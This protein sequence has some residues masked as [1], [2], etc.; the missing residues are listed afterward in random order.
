VISRR[1]QEGGLHG[2]RGFPVTSFELHPLGHDE[3]LALAHQLCEHAPIPATE[4]SEL[5]ER[6]GGNPLFLL[7]LVRARMEAG[8]QATLPS[9]LEGIIASRLDR[10]AAGDRRILRHVAVLG[11]RFPPDLAST[12]L[13]DLVPEILDQRAWH[14]LGEFLVDEQ[15]DVRFSHSLLR[16]VAYEGLPYSRR[17]V[18]HHR[19][20]SHLEQQPGSPDALRLSLMALHFDVANTTSKA[21]RYSRLAGDRA[22]QNGANPEAASFFERALD[23]A[24]RSDDVA[25]DELIEVAEALG[26]VAELAARYDKA[27]SGYRMARRIAKGDVDTL[28]RLSRKEGLLRERTARYPAALAWYRK[29]RT[30]AD[31]LPEPDASSQRAELFVA[32]AGV[33]MHQGRLRSCITW[34]ER[35]LDNAVIAGNRRA[36]A[37]AY[38]LLDVA[39]TDLGSPDAERYR[40]RS[41]PIFEEIGDLAGVARTLGNLSVDARYEGRWD[42]ALELAERSSEAQ[43]R[44]GDVTGL[45]MSRYNAAEVL[46]DQGKLEL[47]E[48]MLISARRTWRAGAFTLGVAVA[49]GALGRLAV[50]SR[51]D[52]RALELIDQAVAA[53]TG[54]GADAWVAEISAHRVEADLFAGRW[55]A[56]LGATDDSEGSTGE[57]QDAALTSKLLRFRGVAFAAIGDHEAAAATLSK[58][59]AVASDSGAAYELALA[60]LERSRLPGRDD[61]DADRLAAA[62]TL[63]S[64]GVVAPHVLIP[65]Y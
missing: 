48:E 55:D 33:K 47:A 62:T 36:E 27:A 39:L 44:C 46:Q 63:E 30:L 38:Y 31:S 12:V 40:G 8:E 16:E 54:L 21:Y 41:L 32:I 52:A 42:E 2:G 10:L 37:H 34:A 5:V 49:N 1:E 15:G 26:D 28:T 61:A 20:A 58:A 60:R 18:V 14:R 9:T 22:R 29:G 53:L 57:G 51:D 50:R 59:V 24:R 43:Q 13:S 56:V 65:E 25:H 4:L 6:A 19:F 17:R 64:L 23:N 45:A 35:A 7:E 3:L 11:D